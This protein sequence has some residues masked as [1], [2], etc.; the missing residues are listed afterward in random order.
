MGNGSI[1]VQLC[2]CGGCRILGYLEYEYDRTYTIQYSVDRFSRYC[3]RVQQVR[4]ISLQL[5][6]KWLWQ[7]QLGSIQVVYC[8]PTLVV[9]WPLA[10]AP[11]L[12]LCELLHQRLPHPHVVCTQHL[13][14]PPPPLFPTPHVRHTVLPLTGMAPPR[15][16][17][18]STI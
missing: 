17:C 5:R 7:R 11:G 1:A 3:G 9:G 12:P 2:F 13:S 8:L 4:P 14:L 6:G 18:A 10:L 15:R 16:R